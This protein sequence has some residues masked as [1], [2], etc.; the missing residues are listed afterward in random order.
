MALLKNTLTENG[1]KRAFVT[2]QHPMV[3]PPGSEVVLVENMDS[4]FVIIWYMPK[5]PNS[6]R[7]P[8]GVS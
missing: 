4:P 2:P 7:L 3:L 8:A 1:A 5:D 6:C